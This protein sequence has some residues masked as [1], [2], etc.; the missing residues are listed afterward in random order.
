MGHAEDRC[1]GAW[2]RP[3]RGMAAQI[4]LVLVV[5]ACGTLPGPKALADRLP[6]TVSGTSM[7]Y[8][9]S[10][11][12]AL[13]EWATEVAGEAG[14]PAESVT[15]ALGFTPPG[16]AEYQSYAIQVPGSKDHQLV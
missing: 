3:V 13:P 7:I 4:G 1:S 10:Q 5:L 6:V 14:V 9:V 12:T 15:A 8:D 2:A 16:P 11:G